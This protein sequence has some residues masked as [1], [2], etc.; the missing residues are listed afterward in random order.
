MYPSFTFHQVNVVVN[1]NSLRKLANAALVSRRI[2]HIETNYGN[3][4]TC[5]QKLFMYSSV[6]NS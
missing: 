4:H 5:L 3:I 2:H 1:R 6:L